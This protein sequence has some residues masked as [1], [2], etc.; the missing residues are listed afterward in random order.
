[1][2]EN[3][4][5]NKYIQLC[6]D[7]EK[8]IINADY[9]YGNK[10]YKNFEKIY[11]IFEENKDLAKSILSKLQKNKN[12]NVKYWS[13]TQSLKLGINISESE[14]ILLNLSKKKNIGIVAFNAEMTLK[15][16]HEGKL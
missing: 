9:K 16:W 15:V 13:S 8:S 2:D 1:M 11:K 5:I 6:L 3:T 12:M 10:I 4:I 14:K 7:E